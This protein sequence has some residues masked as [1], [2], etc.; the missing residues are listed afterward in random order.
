MRVAAARISSASRAI[1]AKPRLDLSRSL[2]RFTTRPTCS[3]SS[4]RCLTTP[5]AP[6]WARTALPTSSAAPKAPTRRFTLRPGRLSQAPK[7]ALAT[8]LGFPVPPGWSDTS[9]RSNVA[10]LPARR[11]REAPARQP[12]LHLGDLALLLH[13]DALGGLPRPRVLGVAQGNP[14]HVD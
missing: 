3:I 6:S 13:N 4:M 9:P 12:L 1:S 5:A 10:G 7:I 8:Q 11:R 2:M 14:R